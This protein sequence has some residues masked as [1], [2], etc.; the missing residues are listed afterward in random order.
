MAVDKQRARNAFA[1]YVEAY[2]PANPRIALKIAHT[3]RVAALCERIAPQEKDLAWLCGILHD[4]GRF[5]QVRVYDTFN[6]SASVS[7]A[8]LGVEVLFGNAD[9]SGPQIRTFVEDEAYDDLIRCAIGTHS[10][11][12]LPADQDERTRILCDVLRDADKIDILKVNCICS[13]KDIYGVTEEDMAS[14]ALSEEVVKTFYE[15]R[16]IPRGMRNHPADILVGH[17]CFA[18]ELV[19]P[20]SVRIMREQGYLSSMLE[21]RF[22]NPATQTT[23]DAMARHMRETL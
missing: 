1:R 3:Y 11:Y 12:R 7:H 14:S 21:R 6:D 16:T 23:F 18:W 2:D 20:A 4:I 17:I 19:Y 15:H 9:P 5:E 10:D 8:A 13:T 22:T